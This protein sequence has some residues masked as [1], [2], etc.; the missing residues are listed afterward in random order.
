MESQ[1]TPGGGDA[2]PAQAKITS[3]WD[4][5]ATAYDEHPLSRIHMG[6]ARETWRRIWRDALPPAPA[7]VLDTGAGTGQVTVLLAELGHRVTG[8]DLAEGMLA[9]ARA[10][11]AGLPNPPAL[12]IGDAVAPPF[13]P[14]S[15][16]AI[17]NRYLLWTLREPRTALANW[18]ELL[19]PGGRL[20]MVDS[21]WFAS[22][23]QRA[24]DTSDAADRDE[25]TR[26]YDEE[27]AAALPLA[28]VETIEAIAAVVRDAGFRDVRITPLPE[29]ERL[30][31]G[32][33]PDPSIDVQL[34]YLITAERW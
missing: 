5:H 15:F 4:G 21:T 20:A 23:L 13:P 1:N 31:R 32:L 14:A 12:R 3:Y 7:D 26:L 17:T 24:G 27:V 25:F 22:G 9:L 10:R 33:R 6:P 2:L 11:C 18:R 34:Q 30:E 28:E 19:R 8:I 16:D 29:I